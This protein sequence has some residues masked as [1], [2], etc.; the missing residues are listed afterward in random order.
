MVSRALG[1]ISARP[2]HPIFHGIDPFL[3]GRKCKQWWNLRKDRSIILWGFCV[4]LI[5]AAM[6][7]WYSLIITVSERPDYCCSA[8]SVNFLT[9]HPDTMHASGSIQQEEMNFAPIYFA[10]NYLYAY[11]RV[12]REQSV[13]GNCEL[14]QIIECKWAKLHMIT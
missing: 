11:H 10:P 1:I 13:S 2:T 7:D 12:S 3:T 5:S 14:S 9:R 8:S 4:T 6:L